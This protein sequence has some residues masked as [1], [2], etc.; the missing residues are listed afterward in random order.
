VRGD[1]RAV[2]ASF[3]GLDQGMGERG[4]LVRRDEDAGMVRDDFRDAAHMGGHHG[5]AAGHRLEQDVGHAFVVA[6]QA[7]QVGGAEPVAERIVGDGTGQGYLFG[8]AQ[9]GRACKQFRAGMTGADENETGP[10]APCKQRGK[11]FEQVET[12]LA[13]LEV[14]HVEHQ[15]T[16][17]GKTEL[18]PGRVTRA[19]REPRTVDAVV[20]DMHR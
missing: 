10:G 16:M 3:A 4:T 9:G 14:A 13:G 11:G 20:E 5:R 17:R 19:R 6:R 7:G 12:A 8:A 1:A 18:R 15:W 2:P